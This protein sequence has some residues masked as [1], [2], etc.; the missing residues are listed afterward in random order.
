MSSFV[1]LSESR[2]MEGLL[3]TSRLLPGSQPNGQPV[4]EFPPTSD[5]TLTWVANMT[6][7]TSLGITIRD[8]TGTLA[9]SAPFTIM[10]GRM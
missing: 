8:S 10:N 5:Q 1:S 3:L 7:G 2:G 6:V 9:Q 4:L